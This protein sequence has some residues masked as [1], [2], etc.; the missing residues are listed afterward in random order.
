MVDGFG[1]K[2][3]DGKINYPYLYVKRHGH[4]ENIQKDP[5]HP[6]LLTRRYFTSWVGF[7]VPAN[8]IKSKAKGNFAR[9]SSHNEAGIPWSTS[10]DYDL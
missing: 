2:I 1:A 10:S 5:V 6:F 4:E 7:G 8:E 9:G 3:R